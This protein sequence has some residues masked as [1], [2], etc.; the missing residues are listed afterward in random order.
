MQRPQMVHRCAPA[1][2]PLPLGLLPAEVTP[3]RPHAPAQPYT[4][5]PALDSFMPC[6]ARLPGPCRIHMPHHLST[7]APL[8]LHAF[9]LLP[10]IRAVPHVR[11]QRHLPAHPDGPLHARVRRLDGR[12]LHP[13]SRAR[14]RLAALPH[15]GVLQRGS[16]P[17]QPSAGALLGRGHGRRCGELGM[18][19]CVEG[20]CALPGKWGVCKAPQLCQ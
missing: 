12:Q 13:L 3:A 7:P 11:R 17:R 15:R 5:R 18:F 2:F 14:M 9:S 16:E 20:P 1:G 4:P 19:W 6:A 10:G 8:L